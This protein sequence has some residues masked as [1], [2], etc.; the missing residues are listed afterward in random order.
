MRS[1]TWDKSGKLIEDIEVLVKDGKVVAIDY[2]TGQERPATPIEAAEFKAS[3]DA[4]LKQATRERAIAAIKA[5][6]KVT[7][8]GPLLYDM[9]VALGLIDS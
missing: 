7:P 3:R 8:W 2:L 6:Q 1:Q 4:Q 5:N 9:A